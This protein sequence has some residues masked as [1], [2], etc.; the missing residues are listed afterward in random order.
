MDGITFEVSGV[1]EKVLIAMKFV[2]L[3]NQSMGPMSVQTQE[4][5]VV[6]NVELN[7][8]QE[9]VFRL[10]LKVIGGYFSAN[11]DGTSMF[12]GEDHGGGETC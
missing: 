3:C 8:E 10:A 7:P 9:G 1:P 5:S 12:L 4:G 2:E 6:E 11:E